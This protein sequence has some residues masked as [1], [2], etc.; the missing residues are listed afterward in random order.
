MGNAVV[1]GLQWG[2]EAKG[3]VVDY[4]SQGAD[5]VVRYNGGNNAG[6][7]VVTDDGEVHKFHIVPAG[8][9]HADGLVKFVPLR[10]LRLLDRWFEENAPP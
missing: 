6:H 7:T 4:L 2:D 8:A 9:L 1:V 10:L 5:V 3:K